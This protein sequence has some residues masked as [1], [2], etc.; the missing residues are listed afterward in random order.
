MTRSPGEIR[1]D[2]GLPASAAAKRRRDIRVPVPGLVLMCA[3]PI[4]MGVGWSWT[5]WCAWGVGAA[6]IAAWGFRGRDAA[7]RTMFHGNALRTFVPGLVLMCA[8]LILAEAGSISTGVFALIAGAALSLVWAF[9]KPGDADSEP[10]A[11]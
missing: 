3:G 8:G 5:G 10:G 11:R 7:I 4:L 9:R 2:A 1:G 6:M